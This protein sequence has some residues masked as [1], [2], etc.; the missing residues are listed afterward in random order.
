[1]KNPNGHEIIQLFE[2][3]S[4]KSLAME[5]DKIGLQVGR[6]NKK[7]DRVMIALDVLEDV[8]DEAIEKNVQLIIAHHLSNYFSS[9]KKCTN[10]YNTR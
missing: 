5:G 6:L 2:Q 1:M 3:F 7:V 8:I 9:T 10:R 4:P